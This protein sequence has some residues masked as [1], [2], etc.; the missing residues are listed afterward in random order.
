MGLAEP[1]RLATFLWWT[2]IGM[3]I[4]TCLGVEK[5]TVI[6]FKYV[7]AGPGQSGSEVV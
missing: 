6:T 4:G 3:Q 5:L 2:Q 1:E 7:V